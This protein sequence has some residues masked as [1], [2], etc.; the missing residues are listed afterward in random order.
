MGIRESSSG[1]PRNRYRNLS[2]S[3]LHGSEAVVAMSGITTPAGIA[4]TDCI[5]KSG[6][7]VDSGAADMREFDFIVDPEFTGKP[8]MIE[9][10]ARA[11][12]VQTR[13][14]WTKN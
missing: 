12:C 2:L 10:V 6:I 8:G 13:E 3:S 7:N 14:M 9:Q 11:R 5:E 1:G 4:R